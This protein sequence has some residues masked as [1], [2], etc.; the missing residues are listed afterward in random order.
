MRNKLYF[1]APA[2]A[3]AAIAC[4]C[5]RKCRE[6]HFHTIPPDHTSLLVVVVSPALD[7]EAEFT[8][9]YLAFP[10]LHDASER[11]AQPIVDAFPASV[12]L[13]TADTAFSALKKIHAS[14]GMAGMHPKA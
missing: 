10:E 4:A 14:H 6:W 2:A 11:I 3:Q 12:G 9:R 7:M 8:E 1:V 5:A 13:S